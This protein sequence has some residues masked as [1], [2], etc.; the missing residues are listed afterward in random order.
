[1]A[2]LWNEAWKKYRGTNSPSTTWKEFKKAF[3]D[4][5]LPLE[6]RDARADQFLNLHQGN[7]SV[8]E[9]S[10]KFNSLAR[11]APNVVTSMDDRV[12]RFVDRL[13]SYLVRNCTIL[14]FN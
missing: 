4:Y 5:Y 3:L 11:Y 7:I 14:L 13:D 10:L 1:M 9:Y 12:H 2:I 6:I 8:R